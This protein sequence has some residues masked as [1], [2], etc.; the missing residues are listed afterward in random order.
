MTIEPSIFNIQCPTS[1]A[2]P[3]PLRWKLNV[4]RLR[5]FLASGLRASALIVFSVFFSVARIVSAETNT[6]LLFSFFRE[7]NGQAGL[8]LATSGD[9][10]KWTEIRAPNGKSFLEPRVGGK[11]MRDPSLALGPDGTFHLVWTTGWSRPL[12]FGY[13]SS[14]DLITWS[15]QRAIPVMEDDPDCQNVWAPELFYDAR[16]AEWLIFW[17]STVP[18]KFKE[19]EHAGD[20]NHRIYC[21]T[22]KDFQAFSPTRLFYDGGFNVIDAALLPAKGRFY[23]VVKDET[24][25]PLKKDLHLAVGDTPAG[26][27]GPAGP[28]FTTNWVEGPSALQLRDEYYV[29]FDHYRNSKYYGAVKSADLE[30]W[31]DISGQVS[32]PRGTRH[33]TVLKV[34]EDRVRNLQTQETGKP[35]KP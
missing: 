25:S 22:T 35:I 4:F 6:V 7:P 5:A 23:L 19:T 2:S 17:A 3:G 29:Y 14:R 26:P 15:G 8:Q 31:Q 1:K 10:L 20:S 18:G 28:A 11:L 24:R 27:F 12:V 13:A 30:H 16:K 21:V 34:P 9:G 33:G 32:F